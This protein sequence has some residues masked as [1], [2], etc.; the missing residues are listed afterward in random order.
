MGLLLPFLALVMVAEIPSAPASPSR[1]G[2]ME[3]Q[4]SPPTTQVDKANPAASKRASQPAGSAV[5]QDS[6]ADISR[7]AEEARTADRMRDAIRLYREG[8]RERPAWRDGWW[9][10]GSLYYDQERFQEAQEALRRFVAIAPDSAPAYALLAL[11]EYETRDYGRALEHFRQWAQKGSRGPAQLIDAARFHWALL[12]TRDGHFD[13]ALELLAEVARRGGRNPDLVEAMGLAG[14]RMA[15]LPQDYPPRRR[16]L[17]WLAGATV[18]YSSVHELD[19]AEEYAHK[20]IL[21]YSEEANVHYLL[22]RSYQE[23][24]RTQEA[25]HELAAADSLREKGREQPPP[26]QEGRSK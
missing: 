9:W 17:V 18:F 12:L 25:E 7:H 20:L 5:P 16:E 4:P 1:S 23:L 22:A 13:Q 21:H 3:E 10:L 19:Q 14:L 26:R 11:C 6:F 24:G 15:N 2:Y 8:V